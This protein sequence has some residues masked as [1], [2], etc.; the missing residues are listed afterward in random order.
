[1]NLGRTS[2]FY[3][4]NMM[5]WLRGNKET[6]KGNVQEAFERNECPPGKTFG[7]LTLRWLDLDTNQR[8]PHLDTHTYFPLLS[9]PLQ[10]KRTLKGAM[11]CYFMDALI[12][13]LVGH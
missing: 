10:V 8:T 7:T 9:S 3:S 2:S 1:M 6:N 5:E 11:T 13:V 12:L 4:Q